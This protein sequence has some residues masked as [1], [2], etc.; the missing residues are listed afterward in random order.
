MYDDT[1]KKI[2]LTLLGWSFLLCFAVN[3]YGQ[4][5]PYYPVEIFFNPCGYTN[6]IPGNKPGLYT[7]FSSLKMVL[8]KDLPSTARIA[9]TVNFVGNVELYHDITKSRDY[10][11]FSINPV[12]KTH[13][14]ANDIFTPCLEINGNLEMLPGLDLNGNVF[15]YTNYRLRIRPFHYLMI[16]PNV[17]F[18]QIFTYGFSYNTDKTAMLSK[19]DVPEKVSR[20]YQIL[21]YEAIAIYLSPFH[22]RIFLAPFYFNNQYDDIS[23]SKDGKIDK[24]QPKLREVGYGCALGLRYKTFTWGYTEGALEVERNNDVS[25]GANTYTKLKFSTKWENQYFTE[26]F[27]YLVGFDIMKHFFERT[28]T[29]FITGTIDDMQLGRLEIRL[30]VMPIVNI[31]RNVSLRPEFDLYYKDIPGKNDTKKF[32]YWLHIHVLF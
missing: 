31:N 13:F 19:N 28:I 30:D 27:G 6:T 10:T 8:N 29:N 2:N 1:F 17:I 21:R 20:D 22:T 7:T 25:N 23:L 32:R 3:S 4:L 24:N 18:Q 15:R 16:T 12:L 26:R 5:V 14:F 11:P 9:N